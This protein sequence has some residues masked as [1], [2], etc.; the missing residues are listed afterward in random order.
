M[1]LEN[2]EIFEKLT[3]KQMLFCQQDWGKPRLILCCR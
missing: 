1:S 3:L 2:A